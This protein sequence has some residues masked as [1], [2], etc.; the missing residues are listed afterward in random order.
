MRHR[1]LA[2]VAI[3]LALTGCWSQNAGQLADAIEGD[4]VLRPCLD[5]HDYDAN[6]LGECIRKSSGQG[7]AETCVGSLSPER[8]HA[9]SL[10]LDQSMAV[11]QA[12][13]G[14]TPYWVTLLRWLS[15][16]S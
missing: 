6:L 3:M 10:C 14:T 7:A 12:K 4:E 5:Q 11:S 2:L 15:T 13:T 8:R 1:K 9:L 16:R